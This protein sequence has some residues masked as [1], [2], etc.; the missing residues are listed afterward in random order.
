MAVTRGTASSAAT[1]ASAGAPSATSPASPASASTAA[2]AA[3]A[4]Q[5]S[6]ASASSQN[7]AIP[8]F[9]RTIELPLTH[10]QLLIVGGVAAAAV[11]AVG[12]AWILSRGG[13]SQPKPDQGGATDKDGES[14]KTDKATT[15]APT[16]ASTTTTTTGATTTAAATATAATAAGAAGK[17]KGK[18][19]AAASTSASTPAASATTSTTGKGKNAA[20]ATTNTTTTSTAPATPVSKGGKKTAAAS[21]ASPNTP[22]V[23]KKA[24]A[25]APA[26]EI[27]DG[28]PLAAAN[29]LK[30]EGNKLFNASNYTEAI[31]KY[32]QAIEL[33]PATEKERAKFYCNRAA[34]HAKQSAHA[35]VIE[36]CNAALAIDPAYGKALQRRGLAHES[37]GQL[38]EAIDDLS[39]AV[40][41]MEEEASLQTALSRILES[42]G[43]SKAKESAAAKHG[44]FPPARIIKM[45]LGT[46][47]QP[48]RED[49]YAKELEGK[50]EASLT[51]EIEAAESGAAKS[52]I[53]TLRGELRLRAAQYPGA[54]ADF[55][56]AVTED[57]T[58]VWALIQQGTLLHLSNDLKGA[59]VVLDKALSL[60]ANNVDAL[61]RKGN[62]Q[63]LLGEHQAAIKTLGEA[64][65]ADTTRTVALYHCAQAHQ[66]TGNIES[67][68]ECYEALLKL[69]PKDYDAWNQRGL[70]LYQFSLLLAQTGQQ[71]AEAIMAQCLNGAIESF[72]S[73]IAIDQ[74]K[75]E[76]HNSLG[77]VLQ[78]INQVEPALQEFDAAISLDPTSPIGYT[79]KGL[80]IMQSSGDAVKA[81]ALHLKAI[82]VDPSCIEA[83]CNL[84]M[85]LFQL[86][87]ID[88]A[89]R[90]YD[91]AIELT[92]VE[93]D[94]ATIFAF[95]EA[96][97]S[98][99]RNIA[100]GIAPAVA[101]A[102]ATS[103]KK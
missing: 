84:A 39:V 42:I 57:G 32:T 102:P 38:T 19:S 6:A 53:Y 15:A 4:S 62:V 89:I 29:K 3:A 68:M 87:D 96:A 48:D 25:A 65:L 90:H 7:V 74:T 10:D 23:N 59:I 75:P 41:L 46:F 14:A 85:L 92:F 73:A 58:N 98:R 76:A 13:R 72:H 79:N 5:A 94:L 67:A 45:Y 50:D 70:S 20:A 93:Q 27:D 37:L 2:A 60:S 103:D 91:E 8:V 49:K 69:N 99:K 17:G 82:E 80:L 1:P 40:H 77:Y 36:D 9:G 26:K 63:F 12:A 78:G 11:V 56:S 71:Q 81:K 16:T 55:T 88:E 51:A 86:Q 47:Q 97:L 28:T 18:K 44:N 95:R 22:A 24:S 54:L 100:R 30:N 43:S 83:R 33:C 52:K 34:C 66:H 35:L 21:A 31:A 101:E 64:I 61:V